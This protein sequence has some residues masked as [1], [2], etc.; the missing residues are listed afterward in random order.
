MQVDIDQGFLAGQSGPVQISNSCSR[1]GDEN[2]IFRRTTKNNKQTF[3][4]HTPGNH[5]I[6]Q[7]G[8]RKVRQLFHHHGVIRL[9]PADHQ[10]CRRALSRL[11]QS[12]T[13]LRPD[14]LPALPGGTSSDVFLSHPRFLSFV[15]CQA[16]G[17][18]GRV[19]VDRII[20]HLKLTF[21]AEKPPPSHIFQQVAL[22]A[23]EEA[24]EYF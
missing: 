12:P 9:L 7:I 16:A 22:M 3:N 2:L 23:A 17:G 13:R 4:C 14:P 8:D 21:V 11:R 10:G 20:D 19:D 18:V 24:A 1:Q 5:I 6:A 15:P